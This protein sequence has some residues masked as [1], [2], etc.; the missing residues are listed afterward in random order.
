M[1]AAGVTRRKRRVFPW[2]FL[3]IQVLF[4]AWVISAGATGDHTTTHC[5]A[6]GLSTGQCKG[7]SEAATGVAIG[8]IIVF[9]AVV[10]V[11]A[12]ITYGVF[13]LARR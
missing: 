12:G 2:I 7:A 5:T 13:R 11:I 10:D 9:W 6:N 1:A 8:V 4:L 3:A